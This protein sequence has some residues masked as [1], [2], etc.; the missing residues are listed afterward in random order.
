MEKAR[1]TMRSASAAN[2][3]IYGADYVTMLEHEVEIDGATAGAAGAAAAGAAADPELDAVYKRM[4]KMEVDVMHN[5]DVSKMR[6]CFNEVDATRLL[7]VL[8]KMVGDAY[9]HE[10]DIIDAILDKFQVFLKEDEEKEQEE[11]EEDRNDDDC[12]PYYDEEDH[13]R[14]TSNY[15]DELWENFSN[16]MSSRPDAQMEKLRHII[17]MYINDP[18][19]TRAALLPA[20]SRKHALDRLN[21]IIGRGWFLTATGVEKVGDSYR[22]ARD[23]NKQLWD[24]FRAHVASLHKMPGYTA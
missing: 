24:R 9:R 11:Q 14:E 22:N 23:H 15:M 4:A 6:G 8:K 1:L 19:V 21:Q 20:S 5:E 16:C 10:S 13:L 12:D 17:I 3:L 2:A 18:V 7:V